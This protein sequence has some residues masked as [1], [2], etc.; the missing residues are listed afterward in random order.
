MKVSNGS[1]ES[2]TRD[3]ERLVAQLESTKERH[4]QLVEGMRGEFNQKL[5]AQV[6]SEMLLF[7]CLFL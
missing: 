5:I 2:A 1:L 7:V 4:F 3:K 6:R